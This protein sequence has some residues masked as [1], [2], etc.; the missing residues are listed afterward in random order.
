[1]G[2]GAFAIE[3]NHVA[4]MAEFS[5]QCVLFHFWAA[6]NPKIPVLSSDQN[7]SIFFNT[8][9]NSIK[10]QSAISTITHIT[11]PPFF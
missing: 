1:L 3:S 11:V 5:S 2:F 4:Q 10:A 8:Y 6:L 9:T 7:P